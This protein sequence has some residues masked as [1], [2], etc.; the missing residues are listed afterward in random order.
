MV[1]TLKE[2][3]WINSVLGTMGISHSQAMDLYCDSNATF[4]TAA[5]PVFHDRTKHA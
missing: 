5:N 3:K 2:L 4:Y 1:A